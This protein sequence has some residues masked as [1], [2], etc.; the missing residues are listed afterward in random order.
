MSQLERNLKFINGG[1]VDGVQR[2]P[3]HPKFRPIAIQWEAQCRAAGMELWFTSAYR[4]YAQQNYLRQEYLA[5]RNNGIYASPPG[6]SSHEIGLAIDTR[7]WNGKEF[8]RDKEHMRKVA[9]IA[10]ALGM[11]WGGDWKMANEQH[12]F[13]YHFGLGWTELKRRWKAK[14]FDAEGYILIDGANQATPS[15]QVQSP[16]WNTD[17]GTETY[18][19]KVEEYK[20]E[21]ILPNEPIRN[22][23]EVNAVGIWQIVK[24]VSDR[25]SVSQLV[26]DSSLATNQGSLIN[27]VK[28]VVQDPWMQF[29]GDTFGNQFYFFTR[30]APFD[31]NGWWG[32][33][34]DQGVIHEAVVISDDLKWYNGPIYSWYQIIPK[35]S[36][37]SDEN[38]IFAHITAVYFEEYA[39]VWGSKP[40]SQVSNYLSFVKISDGRIMEEKALEDLRY[41][42]ESNM[43]LPF[44]RE[45]TIVLK[46]CFGI[47]RGHKITY[48]PT[49]EIFYVDAVSHR[50]TVVDGSEEWVTTLQVSRGMEIRH[51]LAPEKTDDFNYWNLILFDNPPPRKEIV[52]EKIE[53]DVA[54]VYFDNDRPYLI[55]LNE[56]WPPAKDTDEKKME[57]QIKA[58]PSLR[59][60][61]VA[62]N[63]RQIEYA[64]SL[65]EKYPDCPTFRCTGYIDSDSGVN[66]STLP[67]NRAKALRTA[68]VDLYI[69]KHPSENRATI[70]KKISIIPR[71]VKT[72]TERE[73]KAFLDDKTV[74]DLKRKAYQRVAFF[75]MDEWMKDK[76][77]EKEVKGVGW[78]VNDPVF[79]YFLQ[80]RQFN[81]CGIKD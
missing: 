79:Q 29:Y 41:M 13:D 70:E 2:Y 36:F 64:V 3:L 32:S 69:K 54:Y 11:N 8:S 81:K 65:I 31:Y 57:Q 20:R 50:Y 58:F 43:Y 42:V 60:E 46:G 12:H 44:T 6:Y 40:N 25:W 66:N 37:I 55:D 80:R 1:V 48:A 35:G 33:L 19:V 49:M 38:Q 7:S 45:G 53:Q 56:T 23:E 68:I 77:I 17:I 52:K 16:T 47:K 30:R 27:F 39:Q 62:Q 9:K 14:M 18:D 76:E 26:A 74:G 72:F 28:K 67:T 24:M 63:N 71:G 73:K 10:K 21:K 51:C 22:V 75:V 15:Q 78:R 4:T 34:M 59:S 61:L 5:G